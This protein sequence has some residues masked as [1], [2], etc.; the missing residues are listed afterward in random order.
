MKKIECFVIQT[1]NGLKLLDKAT[2][3]TYVL[4]RSKLVG[5][6]PLFLQQVEPERRYISGMFFDKANR[7]YYGNDA[8]MTRYEVALNPKSNDATMTI[9]EK[10]TK[11]RVIEVDDNA[12]D[13]PF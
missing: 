12:N 5:G 4:N 9:F 8:N 13:M 11:T 1:N 2:A 10:I 6:S 3:T 7:Y